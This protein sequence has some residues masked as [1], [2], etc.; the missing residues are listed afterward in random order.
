MQTAVVNMCVQ[1]WSA[2]TT[3]GTLKSFAEG[4]W[5]YLWL[6]ETN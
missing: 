4:Q 2:V 3:A 6:E 1:I 5:W